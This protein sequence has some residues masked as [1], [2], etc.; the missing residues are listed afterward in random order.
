MSRFGSGATRTRGARTAVLLGAALTAA[1]IFAGGAPAG[2]ASQ[3]VQFSLTPAYLGKVVIGTSTSGESIVTNNSAAPLYFIS[4]SPSD[5]SV[6]AEFHA[7]RGTCRGPL[8]IGASCDVDVVFAPNAVGLRASTLTVKLG[9]KNAGGKF[10]AQAAVHTALQGRGVKPSFTLTGGSAGS[11]VVGQIGTAYGMLTNTSPVPL[12]I[13]TVGLQ[14]VVDN[15]FAVKSVTCPSPVLPGGSCDVVLAFRPQHVGSASVTLTVAMHLQGTS[16]TLLAKQATVTGSGVRSGGASP[17]FTLS[18]IDFGTVTVGTTAQGEAVLTNTSAFAETYGTASILDNST[19]AFSL[20]GNDCSA[21]VASGG[22][23]EITVDYAPAGNV[24]RNS[25]LVASVTFVNAKGKSVTKSA[26]T[27][28]TGRGVNPDFSLQASSFP[29][30]SIGASSAG[31]VTVTNNSLVP[32]SFAG[33]SFQ[34]A[35]QSSWAFGGSACV[36]PIQPSQ[37]CVLDIN[38][39]PLGQGTLSVTFQAD[40]QLTVRTHTTDVLRR[41]ALSGV[42]VLP[43]FGLTAPSLASTPKGVSVTGQVQVTNTSNVSLTYSSAGFESGTDSSDFVVVSTTCSGVIAPTSD[44][45]IVVKF[46]P[47]A[48]S[49]GSE[50]ATLKAIFNIDGTPGP[51]TTS[52]TV[53]VS[54]T[55]S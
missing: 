38:F 26:Q 8:G 21:P 42:G 9:E 15:D 46:T 22:T 20:A 17:A 54:G 25:T 34:G 48:A 33:H 49:P 10:I 12:T 1:S 41:V 4:A 39:K 55:E 40:L 2:A 18:P 30:T 44:C 32:L 13:K 14:G 35:D 51:I 43:T 50:S 16:G 29:A 24:T 52:N 28:L 11:V 6:G 31:T 36:N 19:G 3:K 47:S 45:D 23:C 5:D 27:S 7:T 37:S 53:V